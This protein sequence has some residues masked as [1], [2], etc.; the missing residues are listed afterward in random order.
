MKKANQLLIYAIIIAV[1][2]V[3]NSCSLNWGSNCEKETS[4]RVMKTVTLSSFNKIELIGSHDVYLK[5]D[6]EQKVEIESSQNVIDLL[7]TSV[8]DGTW[9]IDFSRCIQSKKGVK[10]FISIPEI[11]AIKVIGSGDIES[12]GT[13]KGNTLNL[14]LDGSGDIDLKLKYDELSAE[15][16]GSGDID[17][18]GKVE[19]Q[20]VEIQGSGDYNAFKMDSE[21]CVVEING[22]G[23]AA[24]S[25]SKK[26]YARVNGSGDISYAGNPE[27]IDV[28]VDGSGSIT[29]R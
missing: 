27:E 3:F 19:K 18:K 15:I 17:L 2:F 29:A 22:S 5:Q 26:L 16:Q 24:V 28:L 14:E 23:E 9:K 11:A 6:S 13:L 25:S 20:K 4:E 1:T 7:N 10:I 8:V 12:D 21:S